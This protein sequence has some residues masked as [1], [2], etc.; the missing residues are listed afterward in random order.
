MA[1][2]L[3]T[4]CSKIPANGEKISPPISKALDLNNDINLHYD[5]RYLGLING[6]ML[7]PHMRWDDRFNIHISCMYCK[8][9]YQDA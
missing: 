5:H 7:V 4:G 8:E 1:F 3:P 6:L 2:F 9:T